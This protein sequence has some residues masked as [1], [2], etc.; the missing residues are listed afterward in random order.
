MRFVVLAFTLFTGACAPPGRSV[1]AWIE[2]RDAAG[3][4]IAG[5]TVSIDGQPLGMTDPS[6]Q[7]RMKIRR[8][9]GSKVEVLVRDDR[10][11][12]EGD[13]WSGSFTVSTS[14]MP[15]EHPSGRIIVVLEGRNP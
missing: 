15:V 14:G 13:E 1:R 2:S 8:N 11:G 9:V 7:F 6:G 4:I 10:P 12:S 3:R 5:A